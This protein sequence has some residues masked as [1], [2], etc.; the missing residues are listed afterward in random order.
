[1]HIL[2]TWNVCSTMAASTT[3]CCRRHNNNDTISNIL[4]DPEPREGAMHLY[5]MHLCSRN[6]H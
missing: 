1:M 6:T 2:H 4:V 5:I 3:A